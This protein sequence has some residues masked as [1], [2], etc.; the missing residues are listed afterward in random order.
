[1]GTINYWITSILQNIFFY[2]QH[3]KETHTCLRTTWGCMSKWWQKV[4]FCMNFPLK[5]SSWNFWNKKRI[6]FLGYIDIQFL[7]IKYIFYTC[8]VLW[9]LKLAMIFVLCM[10]L[11][12]QICIMTVLLRI[13]V[14]MSYC[15]HLLLCV[16]I[17]YNLFPLWRL[18]VL[19]P[20]QNLG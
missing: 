18:D 6:H 5:S 3:K 14:Q 9:I 10:R 16:L 4:H 7:L 17:F 12:F 11:P 15:F 1:M 8:V 20:N 13:C 2:V 19:T